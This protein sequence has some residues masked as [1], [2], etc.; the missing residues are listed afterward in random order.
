MKTIFRI[1]KTELFTLFYSPV[2]WLVLFIFAFQSNMVFAELLGR[3]LTFKSLYG[4]NL[5]NISSSIFSDGMRGLFVS[6]L[7]NLYLFLPLLT[8]GLMSREIKS[9]SIK[10]LY[11]SPITNTKIIFGKY[12][13]MMIY[14]LLLIMIL[15]IPALFCAFTVENFDFPLI[16]SGLLGLYLL[17]CSYAAIGLFMSCLTSYQVVA[18]MGTLAILAVLDVIGGIGQSIAFVRDLTYWLSISGR[19]YEFVSG[20]ICSED[21]L[22]F[23]IVIFLFVTFSILKLDS[24]VKSRSFVANTVRYTGVFLVA[25][26]L[27]YASSRPSIKTYYDST[28]TKNNTLTENSQEVVGM[29]DGELKIITYVNVLGKN[30][31]NGIPS[32]INSDAARYKK[33]TRFKPDIKMEYVYYYDKTYNSNLFSRYKGLSLREIA[34]K[35]AEIND[36]DFNTFLSPEEIRKQVDLRPERN[37]FVRRLL[38]KNNET[39]LRLYDDNQKFPSESEISAAMKRLVVKSPK[40]GF[41]VGHGER[42][43]YRNRDIDFSAFVNNKGFRNSLLNQGFDGVNLDLSSVNAIPSDISIVVMADLRKPLTS[44]DFAKLNDFVARGGNMIITGEPGRQN[45][46]NPFIAQFGVQL[47]KGTIV[48]EI[49]DVTPNILAT[50]FTEESKEIYFRFAKLREGGSRVVLPGAAALKYDTNKG[51]N[52]IPLLRSSEKGSWNEIE[53][54]DFLEQK[55]AINKNIG[56]QEEALTAGVALNRKVGDK[57][58]RIIILGDSDCISNVELARTRSKISGAS[59]VSFI[60]GMFGW[61]SYGQYPIDTRRINAIDNDISIGASWILWIKIIFLGLIPFAL[62]FSGCFIWFKRKRN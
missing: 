27:G 47:K 29:F 39:F 11:S 61:M 42:L 8:M 36:L 48:N 56:E 1:A 49:Q 54:T 55:V 35:V 50:T 52:V 19:T 59:N 14:C 45:I 43:I 58:Q 6:T 7:H 12:L 38:Y 5:W 33:Y 21:V 4:G 15:F 37:K 30:Y 23:L 2:A 60:P 22:Y 17:I 44:N 18:A 57:E 13:S 32:A 53:T 24:G 41:L 10:L 46:L 26:L 62:A 20:L 16:L 34:E 25:V 51:Y 31:Y 9:G 40:V 28:Y 3:Q